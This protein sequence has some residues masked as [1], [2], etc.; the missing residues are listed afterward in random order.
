MTFRLKDPKKRHPQVDRILAGDGDAAEAGRWLAD[1]IRATVKDAEEGVYHT[2]PTWAIQDG[3]GFAH[4]SVYT[5]WASLGMTGRVDDPDGLFAKGK[6][7]RYRAVRV[8][9]PDAVPKAKLVRMIKQAAQLAREET[10]Q[11]QETTA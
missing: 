2:M 3:V 4:V 5:N 9:A 6:S 10:R 11:S 1:L 8:A 7:I